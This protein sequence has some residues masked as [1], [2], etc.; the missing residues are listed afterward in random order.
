MR[1]RA[2]RCVASVCVC[3]A[4]CV[5]VDGLDG[6]GA[7]DA[8]SRALRTMSMLSLPADDFD[9]VLGFCSAKVL[10]EAVQPTCHAFHAA[11]RRALNAHRFRD[12]KRVAALGAA[13]AEA[14][15]EADMTDVF[16]P[17]DVKKQLDELKQAR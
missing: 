1:C 17:I 6:R 5:E 16:L 3:A 15:V 9:C 10:R 7:L 11:A 4:C 8:S 13:L 2:L 14:V 12:R